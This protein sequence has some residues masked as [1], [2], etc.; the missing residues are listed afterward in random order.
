MKLSSVHLTFRKD[1]L[2]KANIS[3]DE[4]FGAG[5]KFYMGEENIFLADCLRKGLVVYYVPINIARLRDSNSTW[6]SG[7]NK[8]YFQIKGKVFRRMSTTLFVPFILQFAIRKRGMYKKDI[9]TYGVVQNMLK[10]AYS[11]K[12]RHVK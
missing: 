8:A 11:E 3:F 1:R 12:S 5:T 2:T 9:S 4:N 7:Y 10:G 6:F